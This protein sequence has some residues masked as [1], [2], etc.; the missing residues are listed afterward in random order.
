M[1]RFYF[2]LLT[3]MGRTIDDVGVEFQ[4]AEAA[5]L[6]AVKAAVTRVLRPAAAIAALIECAPF[7]NR[8]PFRYDQLIQNFERLHARLNMRTLTF[9]IDRTFLRLLDTPERGV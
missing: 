1:R 2:H 9:A 3:P 7:V 4:G 5:Y 8:N 6:E